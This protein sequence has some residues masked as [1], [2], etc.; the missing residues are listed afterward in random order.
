MLENEQLMETYWYGIVREVIAVAELGN[1]CSIRLSYG[2]KSLR[3]GG[4]MPA[5]QLA[6]QRFTEF[7]TDEFQVVPAAR[8][9]APSNA[10]SSGAAAVASLHRVRH[11]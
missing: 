7:T 5:Y 2:T 3:N 10:A 9:I 6:K 11:T 4:F 1:R 8:V